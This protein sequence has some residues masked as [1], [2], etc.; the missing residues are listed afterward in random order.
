MT[1]AERAQKRAEADSP[2]V[3]ELHL[4]SPERGAIVYG[5]AKGIAAYEAELAVDL[6]GPIHGLVMTL[7][8]MCSDED[9]YTAIDQKLAELDD[10][11]YSL[12]EEQ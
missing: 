12:L 10:L 1:R 8:G 6:K 7:R 3:Q 9:P 11:I 2:D 4:E 5:I